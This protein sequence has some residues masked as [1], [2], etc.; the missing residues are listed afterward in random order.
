MSLIDKSVLMEFHHISLHHLKTLAPSRAQTIVQDSDLAE[1]IYVFIYLW[2]K[3][4]NRYI[5]FI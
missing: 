5:L 1:D 2:T 3:F 4:F